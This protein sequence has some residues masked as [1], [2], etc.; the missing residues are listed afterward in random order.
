MRA[1]ESSREG[2]RADEHEA[3]RLYRRMGMGAD[4]PSLHVA[5][6]PFP[7]FQGTQAALAAMLDTLA[8]SGRAAELLTYAH[9]GYADD[10]GFALHR[11][12]ELLRYRSERSGPSAHKL[13]ADGALAF[14]LHH[15]V[16]RRNPALLVAHH[17]E[18]AALATALPICGMRPLL[19]F[20]HTDLAAELPSYLPPLL[21]RAL[22]GAGY[23]FD[24]ALLRRADA[25][26]TVSP[27]LADRLRAH[28]AGDEAKVQYVPLPWPLPRRAAEQER[29]KSRLALGLPAKARVLLYAGNLDAYQ[30]W[31]EV[32]FALA[33][34]RA[35]DPAMR[36]LV[37]T[38]SDARD[39]RAQARRAGV[40]DR[41]LVKPLD[42]E[43]Q[44][45]VLHAAADVAVVPRRSPGGLPIK[46]LDAM[47]RGLPCVA[48]ATASAGLPIGRAVAIAAG[49]DAHAIAAA[50]STVLDMPADARHAQ[51][52]HAR[53]YVAEHHGADAFLGAFDRACG[54][55]SSAA[56]LR[57]STPAAQVF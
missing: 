35:R 22:S 31:E 5:A 6:L 15:L 11:S 47:A 7:T 1:R 3:E 16:G 23:G 4:R 19:F 53:A 21:H 27:L 39:L 41:L 40:A 8:N 10:F 14:A 18:A 33:T 43:S 20:A 56:A 50:V 17:V 49:D 36:L 29:A 51:G 42:S 55:A 2:D 9:A 24:A 48:A 32:V 37:G 13:L 44:R 30:G 38:Q 57:Q 46:L 12:S 34:L 25:V 52:E 45:R 26:A 54:Y 28:A